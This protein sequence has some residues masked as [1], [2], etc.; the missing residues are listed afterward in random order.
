MD[1]N[2][3]SLIINCNKNDIPNININK[4]KNQYSKIYFNFNNNLDNIINQLETKY[5]SIWKYNHKY[6]KLDNIDIIENKLLNDIYIIEDNVIDSYDIY[7]KLLY[8]DYVIISN[9][10]S[11]KIQ[12]LQI[13]IQLANLNKIFCIYDETKQFIILFHNL[14][15]YFPI[16]YITFESIQDLYYTIKQYKLNTYILSNISPALT[17]K[18][19]DKIYIHLVIHNINYYICNIIKYIK[20]YVSN[21]IY[22]YNINSYDGIDY[23]LICNI[24]NCHYIFF[25]DINDVKLKIKNNINLK[26]IN[27]VINLIKDI[28]YSISNIL[29][30]IYNHNLK[31]THAIYNDHISN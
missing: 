5:Y 14:L 19:D 7:K 18:I 6:T 16:K 9:N 4:F 30:I 3:I 11:V 21:N 25:N 31:N 15:Y 22:I 8:N 12:N 17:N 29:D 10:K 20:K 24:Y 23:E 2:N 28:D 26:K 1:K 27:I 13:Y